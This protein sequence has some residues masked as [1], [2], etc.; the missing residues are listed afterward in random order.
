M[1]RSCKAHPAP[2]SSAAHGSHTSR[3]FRGP[4]LEGKCGERTM[5]WQMLIGLKKVLGGYPQA[6]SR[7]STSEALVPPKP[8]ELESTVS[9][10]RFCASCGT[11]SM[12]VATEG[13]SRLS[14][15]G[16]MLSRMASTE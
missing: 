14:V 1:I 2:S 9:I 10:G 4:K 11:R 6:A 5:Y 13:L 16:A 15:G 7:R 12:A 3:R 8:N